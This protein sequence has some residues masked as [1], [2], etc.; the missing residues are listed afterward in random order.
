[1]SEL[2][3][4]WA[5]NSISTVAKLFWCSVGG[6]NGVNA[7]SCSALTSRKSRRVPQTP[8]EAALANFRDAE[9]EWMTQKAALRREAEAHR[10]QAICLEQDHKRLQVCTIGKQPQTI[11]VH[12]LLRSC[13]LVALYGCLDADSASCRGCIII[14]WGR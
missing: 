12:A 1:M 6:R 14:R 5:I 10:K 8:L 13:L 9:Q 2:R 3:L 4:L 11:T 7:L